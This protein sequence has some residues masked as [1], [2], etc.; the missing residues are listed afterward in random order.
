V[1]LHGLTVEEAL[2]VAERALD[3]RPGPRGLAPARIRFVTGRGLHS[4]GGAAR[5]RPALLAYLQ[6]RGCR[7]S[8]ANPGTVEVEVG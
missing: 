4:Q 6:Q 7:F 1:D 3:S 5:I 2:D 8:A